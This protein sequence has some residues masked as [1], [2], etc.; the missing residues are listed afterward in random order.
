MT[1]PLHVSFSAS[2]IHKMLYYN[3]LTSNGAL[4]TFQPRIM[5][6]RLKGNGL[7]GRTFTYELTH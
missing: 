6:H 2:A 7:N 5:A 1:L 3:N 4:L